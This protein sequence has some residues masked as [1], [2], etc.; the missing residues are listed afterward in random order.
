MRTGLAQVLADETFTHVLLMDADLQHRPEDIPTLLAAARTRDLDLV[1][2]ARVFDRARM[3]RARYYSNVVGSR[4]LSALVGHPVRDTQS[5]FRL[6]RC[7]RLRDLPLTST[8]YE[9]ETELLI[10]LSRRGARIGHVDVT[11]AYEGA[12]SHLRPIRDTTRTC[13]LAVYYR[14]LAKP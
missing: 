2:G 14:F 8:G 10:R 4:A 6:V 5:G 11:L 1:V 12:R 13:F 7:G 3:P 9:I